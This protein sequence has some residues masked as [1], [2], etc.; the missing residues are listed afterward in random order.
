KQSIFPRLTRAYR[1]ISIALTESFGAMYLRCMVLLCDANDDG[2]PIFIC[3]AE[4][5][6][7]EKTGTFYRAGFEAF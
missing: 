6:F 2:N 5:S 1:A 4:K 7:A 3:I